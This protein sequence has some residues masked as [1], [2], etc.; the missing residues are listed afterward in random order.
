MLSTLAGLSVIVVITQKAT[1]L[2]R[3]HSS[4]L[5]SFLTTPGGQSYKL[6]KPV[7]QMK[8]ELLH[9]TGRIVIYVWMWQREECY[10]ISWVSV[11]REV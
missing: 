10:E 7:V 2:H 5:S 1:E 4:I 6:M 9:C 11:V 8:Y 3:F